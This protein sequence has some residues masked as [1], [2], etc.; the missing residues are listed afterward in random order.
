MKNAV[1]KAKMDPKLQ[2][3]CWEHDNHASTWRRPALVHPL[4]VHVNSPF[5]HQKHGDLHLSKDLNSN[6]APAAPIF[7]ALDYTVTS[8]YKNK[9]KNNDYLIGLLRDSTLMWRC[10]EDCDMLDF[11]I[12]YY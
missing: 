3:R 7:V 11:C 9:N 6:L 5:H 2:Y 8:P 12:M 4:H 1:F 10:F